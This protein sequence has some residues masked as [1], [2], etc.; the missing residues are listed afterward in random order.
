MIFGHISRPDKCVLPV[1]I[2]TALEFLTNKG[3]DSFGVGRH[4][5]NGDLMF[6]NVMS[7]DTAHEGEKLAEVHRE[8]IDLQVLIHGEEKIK[9][10]LSN[11]PHQAET[12]YNAN[13]DFY[14]VSSMDSPSSLVL[15]P[16]CF[17]VFFP[18]Q[19]HK[20]GCCLQFPQHIKK[21]VVKIHKTLLS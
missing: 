9:F 5:I 18:E 21:A 19:P 2:L 6:V 7:F 10:A 1:P 8:Y 15:T 4:D 14:L 17:A 20:P 3:L 12:E 11:Q 13:D 16:G